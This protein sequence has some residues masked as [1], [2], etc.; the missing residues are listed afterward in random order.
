MGSKSNIFRKNRSLEIKKKEIRRNRENQLAKNQK[1]KKKWAKKN[2]CKP[3]HRKG[4]VDAGV[5]HG[6]PCAVESQDDRL[7]AEGQE[8]DDLEGAKTAD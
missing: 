6:Q 3:Q 2:F 4:G 8:G 7:Q 5:H 1:K